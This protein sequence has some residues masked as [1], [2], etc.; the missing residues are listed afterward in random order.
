[1]H[2]QVQDQLRAARL[3]Q[4]TEWGRLLPFA[5][6]FGGSIPPPEVAQVLVIEEKG[7]IV[8]LVTVETI[9]HIG[10][11]WV[12]PSHRGKGLFKQLME[13][14]GEI[15]PNVRGG[16][17]AAT[18]LKIARLARRMHLKEILEPVFVWEK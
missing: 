15:C 17:L 14:A 13:K 12:N 5:A 11:V 1:M 3:L 4:P 6:H 8:G 2:L 18:N 10:P 16:V 7:K 9:I